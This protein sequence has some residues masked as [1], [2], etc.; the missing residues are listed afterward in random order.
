MRRFSWPGIGL[1]LVGT[2]MLL[3][4]F[5]VIRFEWMT[6]LWAVVAV[7]GLVKAVDGFA[8]RRSSKVFWGT[9]FFLLGVYATLR[10]LDIV[11]LRSYWWPPAVLLIIGF[12]ILMMYV[13]SPRDWHLLVPAILCLGVGSAVVL[14]ELGF[15]YRYDVSEA[16][17]MYWPVG[18]ILFGLALVLRRVPGAKLQE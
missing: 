4:R 7:F 12:S 16:V 10:H 18:L 15:I 5:T 17:R 6:V 1:V 14:A 3:D 2:T 11:E 8:K 13:S 9:F